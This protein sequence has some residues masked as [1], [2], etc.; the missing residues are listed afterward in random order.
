MNTVYDFLETIEDDVQQK[1]V[2][3]VLDWITRNYPKLELTIKW[4]QP[5]FL[6]HG[7]FIIGFSVAKK[8]LAIAPEP[9]AINEL[10]DK[11]TRAG[12]EYTKQLIRMPW[13]DS[14]D[15]EL[16]QTIIDFNIQDKADCTTFWRK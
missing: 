6:D 3:E 12:Y 16:L 15:Y 14:V 7:T 8:H 1:R 5:M 13:K 11:I 4:N 2:K 9:Q 10:E